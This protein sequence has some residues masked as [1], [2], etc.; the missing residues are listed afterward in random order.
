M[1]GE[2]TPLR[3]QAGTKPHVVA[4]DEGA[5]IPIAVGHSEVDSVTRAERIPSLIGRKAPGR[6]HVLVI[7]TMTHS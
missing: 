2:A 4:V 7:K 1:Q 6:Q 3:D 5:R